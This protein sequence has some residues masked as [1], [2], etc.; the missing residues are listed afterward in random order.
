MGPENLLGFA[1][2]EWQSARVSVIQLKQIRKDNKWRLK[3]A[4]FAD[5]GGFVLR[6]GD[7]VR[8]F[9]DTKHIHW[10]LDHQAISMAQFEEHFLLDPKAIDDRNKSD[11]F[12]RVIAVGQALWFCVNIIARDIRRMPITTLEI[13]TIGIIIDS[14]LV[15]YFWKDKPADVQRM[16]VVN[17][18]MTIS[19]LLLLEEN[20]AVR[21]QAYFRTPLNFASRK[22]WSMSLIYIY[23]MNMLKGILVVGLFYGDRGIRKMQAD[24]QKRREML[25]NPDPLEGN[26]CLKDRVVHMFWTLA[27]KL[28]NNS[29]EN[30]PNLDVSLVFLLGVPCFAAYTV[31]R[32]YILVEDVIAFPALPPDVYRTVDWWGLLPHIT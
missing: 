2:G 6:T 3:H 9:L 10:L 21:T 7:G 29:L 20:E 24:V 25:A 13:T 32:A 19:E 22:V 4:F 28:M 15:Y 8:F 11:V 26:A 27:M 5:M 30:D 23:G 17:I 16:E 1:L 14:V 31:I 18:Q 12:V